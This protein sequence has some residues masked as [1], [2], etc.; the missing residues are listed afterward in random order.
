MQVA[1][2][3]GAQQELHE[4]AG[5]YSAVAFAVRQKVPDRCSS[6]RIEDLG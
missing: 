2:W 5:A 6:S 4:G 3:G 1:A